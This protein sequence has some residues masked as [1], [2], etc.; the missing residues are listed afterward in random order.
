MRSVSGFGWI[1]LIARALWRTSVQLLIQ[2]CQ[3]QTYFLLPEPDQKRPSV[4]EAFPEENHPDHKD[5]EAEVD[6]DPLH[7]QDL[8]RT[9]ILRDYWPQVNRCLSMSSVT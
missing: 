6:Q 2:R 3:H 9:M 5:L 8:E 7:Q 1:I 4:R